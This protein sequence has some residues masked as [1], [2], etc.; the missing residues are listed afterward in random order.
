MKNINKKTLIVGI[1]VIVFIAI[2]LIIRAVSPSSGSIVVNSYPE[3]ASVYINDSFAGETPITIKNLRL[4]TYTVTVKLAGYKA[5][6]EVVNL[7]GRNA[8]KT[9]SIILEHS[10]LS[11]QVDSTP[12]GASVYLDGILKGN[13]PLLISD[14]TADV[15]HVLELKLENYSDYLQTVNG[16]EGDTIQIL[17]QLEPVTTRIV[18]NSTPSGADVYLNDKAVGKT[19]L[20]LKDIEEGNYKLKVILPQYTPYE[21]N[22]TVEKGKTIREDIALIKAQTFISITSNPVGAKVFI[23]NIEK[24]VTPYE[25]VNITIGAHKV[26]LELDGYLP[27]ETD[28]VI[29]KNKPSKL[30][31]NLFKLP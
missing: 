12:Q 3:K 23:D 28:I 13:T 30:N 14:V 18:I 4:G 27:Y 17:A 8:K 20:D 6:N 25:D 10:T 21:E 24:G 29:E 22:I 19:P 7:S 1:I 9:I 26:R 15:K 2:F 31:I 11:I 5:Y 16:Q